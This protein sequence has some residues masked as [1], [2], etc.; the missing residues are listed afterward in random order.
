MTDGADVFCWHSST[1]PER[2]RSYIHFHT[3]KSKAARSPKRQQGRRAP[4]HRINCTLA[5]LL[6]VGPMVHISED[7]KWRSEQR[8]QFAQARRLSQQ[9][10]S[11]GGLLLHGPI[12]RR[13]GRLRLHLGCGRHRRRRRLRHS[14][15]RRKGGRVR[16]AVQSKREGSP[17][18]GGFRRGGGVEEED[19]VVEEHRRRIREGVAVG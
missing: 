1:S 10:G 13:R 4:V 19:Q 8:M 12:A 7:I 17:R 2:R 15:R 5:S 6:I 14:T 9:G 11:R 18:R 3:K 16:G